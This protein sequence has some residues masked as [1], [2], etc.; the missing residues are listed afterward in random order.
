MRLY[1]KPQQNIRQ[2]SAKKTT[3]HR[4]RLP[5]G[6]SLS[7]DKRDDLRGRLDRLEDLVSGLS[8]KSYAD[9]SSASEGQDRAGNPGCAE[10][11]ASHCNNSSDTLELDAETPRVSVLKQNNKAITAALLA[12]WPSREDTVTLLRSSH[13]VMVYFH[14]LNAGHSCMLRKEEYEIYPNDLS[15]TSSMEVAPRGQWRDECSSASFS[16]KLHST[17][18]NYSP[19]CGAQLCNDCY[20]PQPTW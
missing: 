11:L 19:N 5:E 15:F 12:A 8:R 20:P 18:P 3:L 4:T 9:H 17:L 10:P 16:S 2:L 7:T 1:I 14:L 13:G 6:L